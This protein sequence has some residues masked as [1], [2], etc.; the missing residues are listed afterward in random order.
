MQ[1]NPPPRSSRD[2]AHMERRLRAQEIFRRAWHDV[3]LSTVGNRELDDVL[4]LVLDYVDKLLGTRSG[5]VS[6][7]DQTDGRLRERVSTGVLKQLALGDS[8]LRPGEGVAGQAWATAKPQIVNNY[9]I[10]PHHASA[11]LRETFS[12]E[13]AVPVLQDGSVVGVLGALYVESVRPFDADDASDLE[14]FAGLVA[15]A[16]YNANLIRQLHETQEMV[17][18]L[19]DRMGEGM[20]STTLDSRLSIINRKLGEIAGAAPDSLIGKTADELFPE[21]YESLAY[22]YGAFVAHEPADTFRTVLKRQDTHALTPIILSGTPRFEDGDLKGSMLVVTDLSEQ[23]VIEAQVDKA[24][25]EVERAQMFRSQFV[26]VASHELRTPLNAVLG[27]SDLLQQTDLDEDQRLYAQ[28]ILEAGES[29]LQIVNNIL[30]FARLE[31]GRL[32]LARERFRIADTT[33]KLDQMFLPMLRSRNVSFIVNLDP[34]LPET[35]VGDEARLRQVLVNLVGNAVKHTERGEIA[36]SIAPGGGSGR[37]ATVDTGKIELAVTV[38]DTGEGIPPG[39]IDGL[40][41]PFSTGSAGA[42]NPLGSTGL[43]LVICRQLVE[44]MG[45]EIRVESAVGQ[46]STFRFTAVLDRAA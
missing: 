12:A 32:Q 14:Q 22:G 24:R 7:V 10:W 8:P 5:Y 26:A 16:V 46:G 17:A 9:A 42:S 11:R 19:L 29:M 3:S 25:Q 1:A 40:F 28:T 2:I 30:D 6:L 21:Y 38:R 34:G 31:E 43:G 4:G 37:A 33:A 13:I 20:A 15:N 27:L 39:S 23:Q 44:M 36:V 18:Q 35:V 45:G 41:K